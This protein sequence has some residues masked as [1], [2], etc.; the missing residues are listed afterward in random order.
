MTRIVKVLSMAAFLTVIGAGVRAFAGSNET[1]TPTGVGCFESGTCYISLSVPLQ[2]SIAPC[3]NPF[4][5]R[6]VSNMQPGTDG[7]YKTAL[8]AFL[9]GKSLLVNPSG[10]CDGPFPR[11]AYLQIQP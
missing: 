2:Q 5:I 6:I 1:I 7:M 9:A 11:L 4:Q 8:A 3:T 10:S